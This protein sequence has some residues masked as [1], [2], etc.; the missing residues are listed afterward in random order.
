M[1]GRRE[2]HAVSQPVPFGAYFSYN[3]LWP[4][5]LYSSNQSR[6]IPG[7]LA[8]LEDDQFLSFDPELVFLTNGGVENHNTPCQQSGKTYDDTHTHVHNV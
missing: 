2:L 6:A 8:V 4:T 1:C 3:G 5:S 7:S